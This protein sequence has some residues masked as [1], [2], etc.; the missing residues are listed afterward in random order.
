M[1]F[2]FAVKQIEHVV[3]VV[4]DIE[5]AAIVKYHAL[6]LGNPVFF[7]QKLRDL[8][9]ARDAEHFVLLAIADQKRSIRGERD[10]FS[11]N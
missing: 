5:I 3:L 1:Q 7:P 9:I 11:R 2:L 4:R 8:A 10:A 6:R